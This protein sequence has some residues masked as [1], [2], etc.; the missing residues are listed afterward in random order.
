M[1]VLFRASDGGGTVAVTAEGD[2]AW[3]TCHDA[4]SAGCKITSTEGRKLG[5]AL[6]AWADDAATGDRCHCG[7]TVQLGAYCDCVP[8]GEIE[9]YNK[10][11]ASFRHRG[12]AGAEIEHRCIPIKQGERST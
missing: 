5:E 9:A 1:S 10:R 11:M 3:I 8:W 7:R 2:V 6:I 12:F 4:D